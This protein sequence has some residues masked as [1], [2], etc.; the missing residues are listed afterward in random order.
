LPSAHFSAG[1]TQLPY[2]TFS[3]SCNTCLKGRGTCQV[4]PSTHHSRNMDALL[5]AAVTCQ[6]GGST[7][8]TPGVYGMFRSRSYTIIIQNLNHSDPDEDTW[9]WSAHSGPH[10]ANV[11]CPTPGWQEIRRVADIPEGL[12]LD[13]LLRMQAVTGWMSHM[14]GSAN[15]SLF[16]IA[17]DSTV[18]RNLEHK[19]QNELLNGNLHLLSHQDRAILATSTPL[20]IPVTGVSCWLLTTH[21]IHS[22]FNLVLDQLVVKGAITP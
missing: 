14:T 22:D 16:V 20:P 8:L 2:P 18:R 3:L 19:T 4:G 5:P 10:W 7:Y 9:S 12:Q 13:S 1:L 11:S 17:P 21:A 6:V 15:P